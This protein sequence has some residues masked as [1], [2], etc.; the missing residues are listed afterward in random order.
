M[1]VSL[2]VVWPGLCHHTWSAWVL[3]LGAGTVPNRGRSTR[4]DCE[5][6]RLAWFSLGFTT[7]HIALDIW[8]RLVELTNIN[9]DAQATTEDEDTASL[10]ETIFLGETDE[11]SETDEDVSV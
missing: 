4:V 6:F 11:V 10:A 5:M 3:D 7:T 2:D 1:N 8:D 9:E